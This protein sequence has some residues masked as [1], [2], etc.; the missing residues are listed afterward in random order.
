LCYISFL[1]FLIWLCSFCYFVFFLFLV[2]LTI[3]TCL[4]YFY[5]LC[6]TLNH[7]VKLASI[8]IKYKLKR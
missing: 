1:Q 3:F 8:K 2:F 4:D 5:F 7:I 6:R